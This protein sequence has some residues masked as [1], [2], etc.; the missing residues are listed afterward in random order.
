MKAHRVTLLIVDPNNPD[1]TEEEYRNLLEN[2]RH[3]YPTILDFQSAEIGEW[4]D[5]HPLNRLAT[6]PAEVARLFGGGAR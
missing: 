6:L 5:D 2:C 4:D 3:V 1:T